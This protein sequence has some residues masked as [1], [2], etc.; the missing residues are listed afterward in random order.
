MRI[1]Y[2]E[3]Y[4]SAASTKVLE[5]SVLKVF[6]VFPEFL[7]PEY[8]EPPPSKDLHLNYPCLL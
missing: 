1:G 4:S 3:Y 2:K 5:V 7:E 6:Y 8:P